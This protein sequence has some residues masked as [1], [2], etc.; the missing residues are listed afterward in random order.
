MRERAAN[1]VRQG[2]TGPPELAQRLS[3]N[4]IERYVRNGSKKRH[5]R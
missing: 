1:V 5:S 3:S 2:D 4:H